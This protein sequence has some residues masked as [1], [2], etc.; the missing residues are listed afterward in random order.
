MILVLVCLLVPIALAVVPAAHAQGAPVGTHASA[1]QAYDAI[2]GNWYKGDHW[3]RVRGPFGSRYRVA[4]SN[5]SGPMIR[6][7]IKR[8][9]VDLYYET[10][11]HRNTY[12]VVAGGQKVRVH[13]LTTEGGYVTRTF[14][15]VE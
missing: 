12:R 13:Y 6:Y 15:R 5:G 9:S 1:R 7:T 8:L 11:N 3:F 10:A 2:V 14:L 4:W